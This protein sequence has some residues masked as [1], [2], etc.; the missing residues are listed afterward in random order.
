M[1][2]TLPA[3]ALLLGWTAVL[4]ALGWYVQKDLVIGTD[5]RLF[6]PSPKTPQQRLL[7]EE[8][9]EGPASRILV[10]SLEGAA[11]ETLADASREFVAALDDSKSFRV[12]TNGEVS[13]D[14]VP[15]DLLAY[16]FLLSPTL[17]EHSFDAAYLHEQLQARARDLASPAGAMLEPLLPR[18]PTLELLKLLQ[19]W[20][21]MQ[22]PNRLYDVWFDAAGKRALLIAETVAPAFDPDRQRAAIGELQEAFKAVDPS[23]DLQMKVSGPGSFSVLME[24]RTRSE[25]QALGAAAT[26]GMILL[27]L[28]AYRRIGSVILSALPLASAG[29]AGLLA[30]SLLFDAV[31]GITLAFGFTLI[32]V[33]QDYP[34]HLLSH[35]RPDRSPLQS[36]RELW[37]TLATG[38]AS[39]CIAYLTFL[40]SG[41][42]GLA[43]LACFTVAALATAGLTTRFLLPRL[44]SASGRDFGES[45]F[46]GRLW[47]RIARLP[48]PR[49]A[50]AVLVVLGVA[51]T[52]L[53][54]G[55]LWENDLG[56]LTPLPHELLMQDQEMRAQLGT[57]DLR[58]MLVIE[59]ADESQALTQLESLD[60]ALQELTRRGAITGYDHAARYVPTNTRQRAH[61]Q[62]LPDETTL[63]AALHSALA[64]TPFRLDVFEPFVRDVALARTLPPLTVE[65][66]RQSPLGSS[67]DML[68]A[69]HGG[70]V[71]ALVTFAGVDDATALQQLAAAA[72]PN[73]LLLDLKSASESLVAQQRTRLLWSLGIAAVLLI[74]VVAFALRSRERVLRVLAPMALTTLILIAVLHGAGVPLTLFHLIA[75]IL[76]AGLGLDYALFFEHAADDPL[77][78]RRTLHA[79]LVCSCSTLMVF[80]LLALS[81]LPVL[82]AIGVTVS[83]GVVANFVLALLLTRKRTDTGY[84]A[85]GSGWIEEKQS[86]FSGSSPEPH[87]PNPLSSLIPHQGSM[88]LLERVVDW[89]DQTIRLETDTHRSPANPL[90][91]DGRLRA[92]H[93]CEYGAQ[94]MAVHGALKSQAHGVAARPGMLVSLRAVAFTCD[95][96]DELPGSLLVEA[97]CLQAGDSSLQYSFRVTHADT[98]LAEGRA[99]VVLGTQA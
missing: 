49:W 20:Q 16:R 42:I 2:R 76:A 34:L 27:M 15:E 69:S 65:A 41:V 32:G 48:R 23:G 77:E 36:V 17:D 29:V 25:A 43:Q 28:I 61:Q 78:Q 62:K 50:A 52:A 38:V 24:E 14:A 97:Q 58:Y 35:G 80:A 92:V 30:V 98:L 6:L 84:E 18:D 63:R 31:H 59:A 10:I 12:V 47:Q 57:P 37:P 8:I 53:V 79:V 4:L 93:L 21:P 91:S 71:S 90:R 81:S 40:F 13:L 67:L 9:G 11:A 68:L 7:L 3:I 94:A 39:T 1:K 72:G 45:A 60:G 26:V 64:D 22:E 83:L 99:A 95:F 19:N 33:A 5:L 96:I 56:K 75:L 54:P 88:C 89:N 46:L 86:A 82:R 66:L 70:K 44:M 74:G 51:I 87:G 85:Q 73:V 55:P